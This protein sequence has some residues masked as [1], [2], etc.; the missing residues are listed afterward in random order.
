MVDSVTPA[1]CS[2]IKPVIPSDT[3]GIK[4]PCPIQLFA[5]NTRLT[6]DFQ[7]FNL[8]LLLPLISCVKIVDTTTRKTIKI[9]A[10]KT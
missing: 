3:F 7:S 2:L 8:I 6:A 5:S 9:N 1:C 4:K 10:I